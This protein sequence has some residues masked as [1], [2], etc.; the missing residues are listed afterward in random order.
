MSFSLYFQAVS[1]PHNSL[2]NFHRE[3]RGTGFLPL[4]VLSQNKEISEHGSTSCKN[5]RLSYIYDIF[6]QQFKYNMVLIVNIK[7]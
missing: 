1:K 3:L 6:S 5:S 7:E 2:K 4:S